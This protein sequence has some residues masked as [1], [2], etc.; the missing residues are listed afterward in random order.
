[1]SASSSVRV[2]LAAAEGRR[3][4][5]FE[6]LE[7]EDRI[8]SNVTIDEFLACRDQ[9]ERQEGYEVAG[10]EP[11]PRLTPAEEAALQALSEPPK[12]E[13]NAG[14]YFAFFFGGDSAAER[15]GENITTKNQQQ[16]QQHEM[17]QQQ[18]KEDEARRVIG[19]AL[20]KRRGAWERWLAS[21][22]ERVDVVEQSQAFA[23]FARTRSLSLAASGSSEDATVARA[24]RQRRLVA[25]AKIATEVKAKE[26]L[27]GTLRTR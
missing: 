15:H 3:A 23:D 17:T 7:H 9:L 4:L 27:K 25:E 8:R 26:E 18:R 19:S 6:V 12:R 2:L 13:K 22:Y 24:A 14:S 16:Q 5:L 10:P 21:A 1:M 20:E 11:N